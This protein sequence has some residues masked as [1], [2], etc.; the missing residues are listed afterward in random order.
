M[1]DYYAV[2]KKAVGG[3][4]REAGEVRRSVYDK[5]RTALIGQLKSIDPPLTTS[6]IS[7]QR[8]ELE[9][10]IRKV[11]REATTDHRARAT[12]A[13]AEACWSRLRRRRRRRP[14]R[15]RSRSRTPRRSRNT[16][17][18]AEYEPEPEYEEEPLPTPPPRQAPMRAAPPSPPPMRQAPMRAAPEQPQQ[19]RLAPAPVA[20]RTPPPFVPEEPMSMM[21]S[22]PLSRRMTARAMRQTKTPRRS[23]M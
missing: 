20:R 3:L 8:L 14:N 17:R 1:T 7:R 16:N 6:E 13:V 18:N 5:A 22:P 23:S 11:E 10:A 19:R 2:L 12:A 4:E 9:E 15:L 21:T